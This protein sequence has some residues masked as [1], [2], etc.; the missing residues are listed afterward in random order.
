[1]FNAVGLIEALPFVVILRDASTN[2]VT[3]RSE[4]EEAFEDSNHKADYRARHRAA[5]FAH[6]GAASATAEA[7][8]SGRLLPARLHV[9][10][11]VLRASLGRAGCGPLATKR[12][13]PARL[14]PQRLVLSA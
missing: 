3:P 12:H 13:L 4:D 9:I 10:G 1:M 5:P 2:I 8:W 11:I 14:D 7:A 6:A